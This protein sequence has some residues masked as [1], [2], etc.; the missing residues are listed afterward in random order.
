VL[1]VAPGHEKP[2]SP[3]K[4]N[5]ERLKVEEFVKNIKDVW[6]PYDEHVRE[7]V[8]LKFQQNMKEAKKGAAQWAKEKK[9]KKIIGS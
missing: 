5:H 7:C 3:F 4:K 8:S 2:S 6:K 1:E 9:Q